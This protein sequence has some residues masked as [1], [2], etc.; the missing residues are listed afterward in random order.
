MKFFIDSILFSY[1]QIFFSNRR[2]FGFA[3]L[4]STFIMPK[5]GLMGLL[6]VVVSN[7]TA[8]ILKF[9]K[10]KIKTGFYG[11]NGILFCLATA[12]YFELTPFIISLILIFIIITFFVSAVLE[13]HLAEVFN[14]PGLSL[15]FILSL[16]I[17]LLFLTNYNFIIPD[18]AVPID[19]NLFAAVP[20]PVKSFFRSL[21][22]ILFQPNITSGILLAAALLFFSRV[23]FVLSV[24]AFLFN[25][26]FLNLILP[27]QSETLL[28]LSGFNAILTGFALGGSLI[29]P[30]RKSFMLVIISSLMIVIMTGFFFKMLEGTIYPILVLPFNFIVLL[31]IY[32]LKFRKDQTDLVLL[33]FK[34]GS[35]EEN[36]Y[37][38]QKRKS[39]FER[40]KFLFPELPFF[41]EWIV[42]QG[43][44]GKHTH[45]DGW[46]NAWD[47]IVVDNDRKEYSGDGNNLSDY[48]CYNLPVAAPLDGEV[49]K[50]VEG[51]PD[52][53][54]GDINIKKNWGNTLIFKHDMGLFTSI[55][56]LA[57][58]SIKVSEGD[59]VKK[60]DI[61]AAC[62]NSGRSPYPHIHFQ[63][64]ITDKLGDHTHKFPLSQYI[65]K[66][67]D[68]YELRTFD[69][70]EEESLLQNIDVHRSIKK[71]FDFKLGEKYKFKGEMKGES[72]EEEWEVKININNE[73][74]FESSSGDIAVF[75]QAGKIFYFT[76]YNGKK[77]SAL[78]YFYLT[79]MQV[80]FCYQKNLCWEDKYSIAELPIGGIRYLTEFLLLYKD[81]ISASGNFNFADEPD[82]DNYK[83]NASLKVRADFPLG[84]YAKNYNGQIIINNEGLLD[85]FTFNQNEKII[86]KAKQILE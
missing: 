45:K 16:Y 52:N 63:F 7:L 21:S 41:G 5:L 17:F 79:A 23:L 11:F 46:K 14:L 40:F 61:V 6:G 70:P 85:E 57:D 59:K 84:F 48:Y 30:S 32:S 8:Y 62:G 9:D 24:S 34:P 12:F 38:H 75:Y 50:V 44:N 33:Y 22:L 64:Q 10:D 78:Y 54:I 83:I 39:R 77:K 56:H 4:L 73:M 71:A 42:S 69:Y 20:S 65:I 15:P 67:D 68:K 76:S 53:K 81:F 80:P 35:P 2:W 72:F 13:H 1:A 55:S 36:F 58:G 19:K 28:I 18:I 74:F 82:S 60:G 49:V 86:F 29:I 27:Q 31:T 25:Y 43:F 3:A 47:F 26:I 37:Y 51:I 66:K